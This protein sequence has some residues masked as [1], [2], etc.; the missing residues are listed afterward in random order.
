MAKK[1]PVVE[2]V[3]D[4]AEIIYNPNVAGF[5]PNAIDPET[6]LTVG[7]LHTLKIYA[8]TQGADQV[9]GNVIVH[10]DGSVSV[11]E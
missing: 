1:K 3:V 2:E 4:A 9:A 7:I 6:G 5:D 8:R 10:Q 11:K